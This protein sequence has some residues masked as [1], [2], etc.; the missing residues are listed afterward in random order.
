MRRTGSSFPSE[1][2]AGGQGRIVTYGLSDLQPLGR[3]RSSSASSSMAGRTED[4]RGVTRS[5]EEAPARQAATHLHCAAK[6]SAVMSDSERLRSMLMRSVSPLHACRVAERSWLRP[7]SF[8]KD[9]WESKA[10]FRPFCLS[11]GHAKGQTEHIAAPA[12][13]GGSWDPL[14][15]FR[16]RP[17]GHLGVCWALQQG[18]A[19]PRSTQGSG[20]LDGAPKPL[21]TY[22]RM[23][24]HAFP[25]CSRLKE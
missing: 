6:L 25:P 7:F 22:L 10:A 9:L 17:L 13:C 3:T 20:P 18:R 15:N 2:M 23:L 19:A 14:Q 16:V 5:S 11:P 21:S 24:G 12:W 8:S 1:V 4:Q